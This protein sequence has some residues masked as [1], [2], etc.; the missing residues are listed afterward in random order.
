[1]ILAKDF[2]V[3]SDLP[4]AEFDCIFVIAFATI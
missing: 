4:F 3:R 2:L 1:M